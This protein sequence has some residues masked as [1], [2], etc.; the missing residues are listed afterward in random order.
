MLATF[1]AALNILVSIY[2][3]EPLFHLTNKVL[4][5]PTSYAKMIGRDGRLIN[6]WLYLYPILFFPRTPFKFN[7]IRYFLSKQCSLNPAE[8]QCLFF[9][10]SFMKNLQV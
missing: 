1:N 5:A 2:K 8:L 9:Y 7:Q 10:I 6:F 4:F 3:I